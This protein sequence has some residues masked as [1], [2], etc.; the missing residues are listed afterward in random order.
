MACH[1]TLIPGIITLAAR[2]GA[3]RL[4]YPLDLSLLRL[5]QTEAVRF[6]YLHRIV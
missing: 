2:Q 5:V 4:L 3:Q 1:L 6:E